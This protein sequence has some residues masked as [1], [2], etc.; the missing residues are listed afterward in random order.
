MPD[1]I[2]PNKWKLLYNWLY[3]VLTLH[4]IT[5]YFRELVDKNN[6]QSSHQAVNTIWG[7]GSFFFYWLDHFLNKRSFSDNDFMFILAMAGVSTLAAIGSK[8]AEKSK[9]A[10]DGNKPE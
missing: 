10:T 8:V 1:E 9:G 7:L 4:P 6:P 5:N 2:K 3:K